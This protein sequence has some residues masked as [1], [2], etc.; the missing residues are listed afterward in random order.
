MSVKM[1]KVELTIVIVWI[2]E[3]TYE[4]AIILH[5]LKMWSWYFQWNTVCIFERAYQALVNIF[6]ELQ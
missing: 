6:G 3:N 5:L 1:S 2:N 4:S